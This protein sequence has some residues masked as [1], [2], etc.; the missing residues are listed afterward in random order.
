MRRLLQGCNSLLHT[1]N[2]LLHP[3]R[4][5]PFLLY[6]LLSGAE[7]EMVDVDLS[8]LVSLRIPRSRSL[9]FGA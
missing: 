7:V 1:R 2:R 9:A 3:C 4:Y 6:C 5:V 8:E